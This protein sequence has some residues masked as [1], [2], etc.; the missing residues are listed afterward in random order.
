MKIISV[1]LTLVFCLVIVAGC[2]GKETPGALEI[3]NSIKSF[4]ADTVN[5]TPLD[6]ES[7]EP[8]FGLSKDGISQFSGYINGSDE[9]F[10]IIAVFKYEDADTREKIINGIYSL[11]NQMGQNFRIANENEITEPLIAET[12][13]TIILCI[14]DKGE[15]AKG[16]IE[17]E[18]NATIIS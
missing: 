9:A 14:M 2:G 15:K 8:Y 12:D 1:V 10:D 11:S 5:W 6:K 17:N 13:D 18:L 7:L 4:S 3:S 16:Y